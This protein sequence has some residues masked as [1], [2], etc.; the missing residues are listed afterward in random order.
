MYNTKI[1]VIDSGYNEKYSECI[2]GGISISMEENRIITTNDLCDY[3]GHGTAILDIIYRYS[4]NIEFYIVKIF[5]RELTCNEE[6]LIYALEYI[7][8]NI[9][10]NIINISCGITAVKNFSVLER[11]CKNLSQKG[12]IIV[13]AFDN[14][15][16]ISYPAALE[17]VIGVDNDPICKKSQDLVYIKNSSIDIFAFGGMQRVKWIEPE[18]IYVSGSSYACAH[19]TAI[20]SKYS[21]KNVDIARCL[22]ESISKQTISF[23][24][25]AE[26]SLRP[27]FNIKNAILFPYNKE[28]HSLINYND[29]LNFNINGVYDIRRMGNVGRKLKNGDCISDW[30]NINWE[31]D[32]DTIIVG[33]THI[34]SEILH[35]DILKELILKCAQYKK[36]MYSFDSLKEYRK[37]I[38]NINFFYPDYDIG[39]F[40]NFDKLYDIALPVLGI[41]GTSSSQGKYTLQLELRKRFLDEGYLVGQLGTEPSSILFEMD[42]MFHFGFN[43]NLSLYHYDF[44]RL[45]NGMINK[46][47]RKSPDIILAGSQ[48]NTVPYAVTNTRFIP[49][50]QIDFLLGLNPD[51]VLLC[52]N[53]HDEITYIKRTIDFIESLVNCTV[54]ALILYP[55]KYI[56]E[57]LFGIK[58]IEITQ[59]EEKILKC[60]LMDF[61][62]IPCYRLG[63]EADMDSLLQLI[64]SSFE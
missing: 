5:D 61:F 22:L 1:C 36:N 16:A 56:N 15:G 34:L 49:S 47:Q 43:T 42:E 25:S 51:Y 54:I 29:L 50:S 52:I 53:P 9:D 12:V 13:S 55:L 37:L 24:S 31:N 45:V 4:E 48:S 64:I 2:C 39:R 6:V 46:I 19:I 11:V 60:K 32:F 40:N 18:Y 28:M 20:I 35:T 23:V 59:S 8:K 17:C 27:K 44:I 63:Q 7:Y 30:V 3:I 26:M 21:C 14:C 58:K 57:S 33:H 10:C 38:N 41:F 62:N